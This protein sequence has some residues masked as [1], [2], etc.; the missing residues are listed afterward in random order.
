GFTEQSGGR[1]EV[2]TTPGQGTRM[3]LILPRAERAAEANE[4][5][6]NTSAVQPAPHRGAALLV[7]DDDE[8]AAVT[9]DMLEHLGW[10]VT[11][12]ASP[13]AALPALAKEGAGVDLV[14]SDVM[15]PGGQNGI[16]LARALRSRADAPPIVLTSGYAES[17]RR[18][19]ESVGVPL[20]PKP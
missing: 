16:A 6:R 14:F 5:T 12:L 20:L 18:E 10:R 13:E 9:G 7:E 3:T 19:A 17:V 4:E 8:V 2:F 1:V 11:R 15:M